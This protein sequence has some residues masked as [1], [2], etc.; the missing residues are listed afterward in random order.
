MAPAD[1]E[2]VIKSCDP[3]THLGARDH[4][5]IL[6][7]GRLG[8][9]AGDVAGLKFREIEWMEGTIRMSGKNRSETRLP[10]PQDIGDAIIHYLDKWRPRSSRDKI[11]LTTR[12]PYEPI[13]SHV[14]SQ[15]ARRAILRAGVDA[16]SHGAHVFRHSAATAMLRKGLS[17]QEIGSILRHNSIET[18]ALYAKIDVG[19]LNQLAR[20]WPEVTKC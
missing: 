1:L 8:L 13:A 18:T 9:R 5:V 15:I 4:A 7:L 16:P 20:P 12:A 19:M 6:L 10:L 11:F 3:S 17:L 2:E 14:V